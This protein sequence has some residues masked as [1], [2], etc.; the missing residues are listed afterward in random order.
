M[1]QPLTTPREEAFVELRQFGNKFENVGEKPNNDVNS[2]FQFSQNDIENGN[3][4]HEMKIGGPIIRLRNIH[5]TYLLGIEG[6]P[7]L[8]GVTLTINKGE[9]IVLFGKSGGGKTSMLNIIGTI[10]KPTKGDLYVGDKRISSQTTDSEVAELRLKNIGFCFQTFN[11]ISSMTAI[12]NVEL[13]M[14]LNGQLTSQE[15]H[16][17]AKSLL[18]KMGLQHR[19]KHLPSQLSGGEQQRVTIARAI[20]NKP[21]L[22]LLDEPTGDLD[23]KN[24]QM[25][26]SLL[27][28]LNR[29][30]GITCVFVTHDTSMK[31]FA[32]RCVH[33]MD[34]KIHH[35]EEIPETR[36]KQ[37][38]MELQN[39]VLEGKSETKLETE[40]RDPHMYYG[41]HKWL[42]ERTLT[43]N[44]EKSK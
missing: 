11:L 15:I 9:F 22:L 39:A 28:K 33:M 3:D 8:R 1:Y 10:D 36:R 18:D 20:A 19:Y 21:P 43:T 4:E 7:A 37:A 44:D 38:E 25:V 41:Y 29:C 32:H 31:Y 34:G 35:I 23:S 42:H 26:M 17:R 40:I 14:I 6:V 13:P 24:T 12:E 27:V 2:V 16:E 30:D 5:K